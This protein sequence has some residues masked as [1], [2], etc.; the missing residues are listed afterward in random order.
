MQHLTF[1][2]RNRVKN[3]SDEVEEPDRF[4][5]LFI[6]QRYLHFVVIELR[7]TI[8]SEKHDQYRRILEIKQVCLDLAAFGDKLNYLAEHSTDTLVIFIF[9]HK[10]FVFKV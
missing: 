2:K 4:L 3:V 1:P 8:P 9:I 7:Y 6:P 10:R 5:V